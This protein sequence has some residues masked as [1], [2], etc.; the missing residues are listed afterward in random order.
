MNNSSNTTNREQQLLTWTQII[1]DCQ[2]AKATGTKVRDWLKA[3]NISKDTYYY[4]YREVKDSYISSSLPEIV[5]VSEAIVPSTTPI[6]MSYPNGNT[7]LVSTAEA[8]TS[9]QSSIKLSINGIDIEVSELTNP[10]LLSNVI[11]AV[12]YA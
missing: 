7:S 9:M 2:A 6:P 5:P 4:W 12:R 3:N 10:E 11:K 8:S 1:S